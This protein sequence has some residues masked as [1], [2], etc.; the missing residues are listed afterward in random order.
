MNDLRRA[1]FL[2]EKGYVD[3]SSWSKCEDH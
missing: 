1:E 2:V 3:L